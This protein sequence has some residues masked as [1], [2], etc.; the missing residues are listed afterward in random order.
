MATLQTARLIL[1][2]WKPSDFVPFAVMN[3]DPAV[4]EFMPKRLDRAASDAFATRLRDHI[5]A[6]GWGL[7]AVEVAE[8]ATFIG[9]TGL[10]IPAFTAQFTPCVEVGWRLARDH[11][12]HGYAT[13]AAQAAAA[14]GF[15]TLGLREIVSFTV[16]ANVRSRAVMARLGMQHDPADDFEHPALPEGHMLRRHLLYRLKGSE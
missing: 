10:S 15:D 12:G 7:W 1:R 14:Y 16:P 11:W 5:E 9:Y 4:M 2:Q 13:E 6:K 3:G 8:M